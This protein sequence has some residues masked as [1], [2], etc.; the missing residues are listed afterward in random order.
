ML[1]REA[2]VLSPGNALPGGRV[3]PLFTTGDVDV[4]VAF[5]FGETLGDGPAVGLIW[6]AWIGNELPVVELVVLVGLIPGVDP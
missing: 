1:I 2:Q 3:V 4:P 6:W 5:L